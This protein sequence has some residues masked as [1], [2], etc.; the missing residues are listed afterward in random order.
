MTG[1]IVR[2]VLLSLVAAGLT[3]LVLPSAANARAASTQPG[4]L[5][6]QTV[7]PLRGVVVKVD[8]QVAR[9]DAKGRIQV[10]VRN[11]VDLDKRLIVPETEISADRKVVFDRFRGDVDAGVRGKVVELGVRTSRL[12]SW[13]FIDRFGK[14]VPPDRVTAMRLRSNTGE[15]HDLSGPD[16][17]RPRWVAE[18]RTQ[19]GPQGLVSKQLYYVVDSAMVDGTSVVNRAG[20]KFVPWEQQAWVVQLLFF[21][22][23]FTATDMFFT[24]QVGDGIELTR[25]DGDVQRLPFGRDGTALVPDLPRGTYT[26]TVFGGGVS[27]GRPVSISKDQVVTLT[28]I[29]VAD[30]ALVTLA[31]LVVAVGLVL[32]GRPHLLTRLRR[33]GTARNRARP[34]P[35]HRRRLPTRRAGA[36]PRQVRAEED[37]P[38][39]G[40]RGGVMLLLLVAALAGTLLPSGAARADVGHRQDGPTPAAAPVP[41][42]AY[43]YIWF[44]PT[45]WNR[46]KIDYP[47]LGRYSSDDVEIMRRH[48]RMAK[49]AGIN[50]F[51]VS[52]KHTPQLDERLTKLV[53]V[54]REEN[55]RLGI[56]Y[57]GLDF[58]RTPL[59]FDTVR[60]DL[61]FFATRYA[62]DP[63]FDIFGRPLVVW[64]GSDRFTAEQIKATVGSVRGKL[65]VLGNA[66]SLE[67]IESSQG[68]LDGQAYYW[69]SV[70]PVAGA[71]GPKL[72][73]MSR[74]VHQRG[75]LWIAPVTPGFDARLVGGKREVPRREG[76]T[77]RASFAAARLSQPDAIGVISWNEFSENTHIE[78][79]ERF[80]AADINVL[81]DLLGVRV[82]VDVPV[83][84]SEPGDGAHWGLN[85]WGA[86]LA[87]GAAVVLLPLGVVFQ[88]RRSPA[89]T[90]RDRPSGTGPVD[91][92]VG[93]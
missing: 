84:S 92:V 62:T 55:F 91:G 17:A 78:P 63:V 26:I 54:A 82:D 59:A 16:V 34:R 40:A 73:E 72:A 3:V 87:T 60:T 75:G 88:R 86:L 6:L 33:T 18:S 64:T 66:K 41:V 81:A 23:S 47:L 67:D 30:L 39:A 53:E 68:V 28:V 58:S 61:S 31:V 80:G 76:D 14:A 57:Q 79:S 42:L 44:N 22:V 12:V 52:W 4:T 49:S 11:F 35:K 36:R 1:R 10:R 71:S 5:R 29:S 90:R 65:L 46:A 24:R 74:A 51:L 27:F 8:G 45:S 50:G 9:S 77:L 37:R 48:V 21:R 56:V 89:R 20:Q 32:L 7:P 83:D 38:L 93:R 19:Q 13:S 25:A 69:S 43:Y 70:D 2:A 15:I 85:A